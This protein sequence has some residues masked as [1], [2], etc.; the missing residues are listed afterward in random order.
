M[1]FDNLKICIFMIVFFLN[2]LSVST[3]TLESKNE[4]RMNCGICYYVYIA[5][6]GNIYSDAM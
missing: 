2:S 3:G 5:L 1:K 6:H 4:D